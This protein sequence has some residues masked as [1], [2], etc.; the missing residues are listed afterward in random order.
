MLVDLDKS[1]LAALVRG[2]D[3]SYEIMDHPAIAS[4]GNYIG[5]HNDRW[6]WKWDLNSWTEDQLWETYQILK[7]PKSYVKPK[8][9][10]ESNPSRATAESIYEALSNINDVSFVEVVDNLNTSASITVV[11]GRD[12]DIAYVLYQRIP[13]FCRLIGNYSVSHTEDAFTH[14]WK[15]NR[16]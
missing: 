12:E 10:W 2:M 6:E 16:K 11:G 5:G 4:K 14:T 1:M 15:I 8:L 13:V 9:E 7:N 3:P